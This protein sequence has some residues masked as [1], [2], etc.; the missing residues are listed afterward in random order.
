[1][2]KKVIAFAAI[3]LLILIGI[4]SLNRINQPVSGLLEFSSLGTTLTGEEILKDPT[5]GFFTKDFIQKIGLNPTYS[6]QLFI[7]KFARFQNPNTRATILG[8]VIPTGRSLERNFADEKNPRVISGIFEHLFFGFTPLN[9]QIQVLS[10]N[11]SPKNGEQAIDF[12]LINDF[13]EGRNASFSK[14]E[15]GV[16]LACHQRSGPIF[17]AIPWNEVARPRF[18]TERFEDLHPTAQ[19]FYD[20]SS[21]NTLTDPIGFDISIRETGNRVREV[22]FCS[23]VCFGHK[24]C[25]RNIAREA[26]HPDNIKFRERYSNSDLS[27]P[28]LIEQLFLAYKKNR[29]AYIA[30]TALSLKGIE[31]S[32][33]APTK[34]VLS[35][36]GANRSGKN[37]I[38]DVAHDPLIRRSFVDSDRDNPIFKFLNLKKYPNYFFDV[39]GQRIGGNA[40]FSRILSKS[41]EEMAE[42][43]MFLAA[44]GRCFSSTPRTSFSDMQK[45]VLSKFENR[46]EDLMNSKSF[47]DFLDQN[48]LPSVNEL[49][50]FFNQISATDP[51]TPMTSAELNS[52]SRNT[53]SVDEVQFKEPLQIYYNKCFLCHHNG[54]PAPELP[55]NQKD[56][57]SYVGISNSSRTVEFMLKNNLMPPPDS[58]IQLTAE[59][60][61]TLINFVK[62]SH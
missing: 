18:R 7:D 15:R 53:E 21:G 41:T 33:F 6:D 11:P 2:N 5:F 54:G 3:T 12:L 49:N 13:A 16:C 1:M 19:L 44:A 31:A 43:V 25:E 59:Q 26:I 10:F 58:K 51:L 17:S 28:E 42:N 56:I 32:K 14:P 45:F 22:S 4:T 36:A 20:R 38:F 52:L 60:R 37:I 23:Q 27:T 62:A 61:E 50:L 29:S 39:N 35:S 48:W 46:F 30:E 57:A 40:I 8:S 55:I 9:D 47:V 24:I 34:T